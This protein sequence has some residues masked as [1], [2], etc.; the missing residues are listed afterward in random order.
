MMK[1]PSLIGLPVVGSFVSVRKTLL[2][3]GCPAR[4]CC[5]KRF[6]PASRTGHGANGFLKTI[7]KLLPSLLVGF[8]D[9]MESKP[10]RAAM[11]FFGLTICC[12]RYW[13]SFQ[14]TG[15]P[16]LHTA[17]FLMWMASVSGFLLTSLALSAR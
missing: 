15:T 2:K 4:A 13:K 5:G 11:S 14:V 7:V 6:A 9:L 10:L 1:G 12:Q 3:S 8:T 16:S 17:F